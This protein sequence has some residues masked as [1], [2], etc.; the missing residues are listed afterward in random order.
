M[1]ADKDV[2]GVLQALE[3]ILT[4]I[5]AT[6]NSSPRCLPADDLGALAADIFGADRVEVEPHLAR[7]IERAVDLA[8]EEGELGGSGVIVTG[9][10]VTVGESR[11]ILVGEGPS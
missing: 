7:A 8:E 9:S 5:V 3:P 6:Q 11:S 10:V 2:E 1:L 4:T